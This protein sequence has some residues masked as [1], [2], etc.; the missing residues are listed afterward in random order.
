M[1]NPKKIFRFSGCNL[2]PLEDLI[3]MFLK[4]MITMISIDV[5]SHY[6]E[7]KDDL[8]QKI[9]ES[10]VD[11]AKFLKGY[12]FF[13]EEIETSLETI[14][15]ELIVYV[16]TIGK[17]EIFPARR[18]MVL[19][20]LGSLTVDHVLSQLP[21]K[22]KAKED[23]EEDSV[24]TEDKENQPPLKKVVLFSRQSTQRLLSCPNLQNS[25]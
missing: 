24:I 3:A 17:I 10:L 1:A 18:K 21:K 8:L 7:D 16:N 22:R 11:A 9:M 14:I 25:Q 12:R 19:D 4:E 6:P 5:V 15:G 2:I 20:F 23:S 13:E